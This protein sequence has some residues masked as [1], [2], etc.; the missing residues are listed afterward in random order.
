MCLLYCWNSTI[1]LHFWPLIQ[2]V[3]THQ[4][5]LWHQRTLGVQQFSSILTFSTSWWLQIPQ[6]RV[7]SHNTAHPLHFSQTS[8]TASPN[9]FLGFM[10]QRFPCDP[11]WDSIN[12]LEQVSFLH[13]WFI[14]N[15]DTAQWKRYTVQGTWEG[16]SSF[17]AHSEHFPH[18]SFCSPI[19]KV[20]KTVLLGF[21]GHFIK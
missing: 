11:F 13:Y 14:I 7:Q 16:V 12:L 5:I 1:V 20:S 2:G 8:P 19:Q 21:Y 15:S 9:C 6:V 10:D 3:F 18:T 17:H 4:G